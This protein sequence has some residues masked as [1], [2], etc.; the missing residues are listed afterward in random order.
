MV[1]CRGCLAAMQPEMTSRIYDTE[2]IVTSTLDF[3][4]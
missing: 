4:W 3:T 1:A 2:L